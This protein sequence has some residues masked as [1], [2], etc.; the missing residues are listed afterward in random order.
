MLGKGCSRKASGSN[1]GTRL[2][3]FALVLNMG[4]PAY[5]VLQTGCSHAGLQVPGEGRRDKPRREKE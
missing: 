4:D 5:K 2:V 1:E 3:G